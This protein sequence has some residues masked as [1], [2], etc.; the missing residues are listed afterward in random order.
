[1]R[2]LAD[3]RAAVIERKALLDQIKSDNV[4]REGTPRLLAHAL[5]D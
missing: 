1:M 2:G 4:A 3:A 5:R